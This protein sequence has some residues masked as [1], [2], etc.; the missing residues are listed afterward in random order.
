MGSALPTVLCAGHVVLLHALLVCGLLILSSVFHIQGS[1][2]LLT[3]TGKL[4]FD[5]KLGLNFE[6][7]FGY[8]FPVYWSSVG[9]YLKAELDI[10]N[11][12]CILL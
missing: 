12:D 4:D 7:N 3:L 10:W 8:I 11:A 5:W 9:T 1:L 6:I 2:V